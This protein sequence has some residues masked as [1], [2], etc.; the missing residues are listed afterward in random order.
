[1]KKTLALILIL[2]T[3]CTSA[4]ATT[5]YSKQIAYCNEYVTLRSKPDTS[6]RGLCTVDVGEV[7]MASNYN[8]QFSYCCYN[9]KFGYILNQYL[10][11]NIQPWSE[12]SFHIGNCNEWVS[13]R[14]MPISDA[15]VKT[16]IPLGAHLDQ[17]FYHDGGYSPNSFVYVK[18]NGMLGFVKWQYVVA[19]YHPGWQ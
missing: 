8:S 17:V 19:D 11:S 15:S 10:S 7:V 16:R 18:Y 12:G 5:Y 2:M 6:S 3:L 1:M 14:S 13:L 4:F 9:G